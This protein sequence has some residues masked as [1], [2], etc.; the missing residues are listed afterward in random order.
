MFCF[1]CSKKLIKSWKKKKERKK[2]YKEGIP[3]RGEQKEMESGR[4]EGT[5]A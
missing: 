5:E 2:D 4:E 1:V 3:G